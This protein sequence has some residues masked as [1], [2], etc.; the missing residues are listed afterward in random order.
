MSKKPKF[1]KI[2]ELTGLP[3]MPDRVPGW[4]ASSRTGMLRT[5][6]AKRVCTDAGDWGSITIW[7]TRDGVYHGKFQRFFSTINETHT[8]TLRGLKSWLDVWYPRMEDRR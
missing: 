3:G 4:T 2:G 8:R 1:H 7:H 5:L 6:R